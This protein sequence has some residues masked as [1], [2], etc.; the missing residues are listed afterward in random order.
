MWK[1]A[2]MIYYIEPTGTAP[3]AYHSQGNTGR[4]ITHRTRIVH[5]AL[6]RSGNRSVNLSDGRR[7][8]IRAEAYKITDE[9]GNDVGWDGVPGYRK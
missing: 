5:T 7:W 1:I 9:S 4:W 3:D 8:H 2:A 6:S